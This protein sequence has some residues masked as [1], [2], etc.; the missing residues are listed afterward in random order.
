MYYVIYKSEGD[1]W[2]PGKLKVVNDVWEH[3]M[4]AWGYAYNSF[5]PIDKA[6]IVKLEALIGRPG[7]V[8]GVKVV[9]SGG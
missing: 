1:E 4:D 7:H 2:G 6:R 5:D 9:P 3:Y 8:D